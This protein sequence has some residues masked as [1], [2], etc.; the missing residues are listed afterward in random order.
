MIINPYSFGFN[1]LSLSPALWLAADDIAQSDGTA[2]A[3]WLDKSGNGRNATQAIG[4]SQPIVK[5]GVLN[6]RNV[7]RFD[8]VNDYLRS[9]SFALG[10]TPSVFVVAKQTT[11]KAG[12]TRVLGGFPDVYLY[13]GTDASEL[14]ATFY[15][16][17]TS[18]G[19]VLAQSAT[20]WMGDFKIVSSIN[21]GT[22]SQFINGVASTPRL[23]AMSSFTGEIVVGGGYFSSGAWQTDQILGGDI[24]EIIIIPSPLATADRQRVE[25][26]LAAK[27]LPSITIP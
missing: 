11:G 5:T 1:P 27:W 23:N 10:S 18:W 13:C 9:P 3:T 2:V 7:V 22:D 24:A 8:G 21:N 20:T 14:I 19:T 12:Y 6:G 17:G 26:Y 4:A 25:R 15:G 16:N